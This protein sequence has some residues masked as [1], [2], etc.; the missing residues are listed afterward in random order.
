[1]D[2]DRDTSRLRPWHD[3]RLADDDGPLMLGYLVD[4]GP[5]PAE[6]LSIHGSV[7][8]RRADRVT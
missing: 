7:P 3:R 6:A 2:R 1:M 5:V 8:A 4:Q